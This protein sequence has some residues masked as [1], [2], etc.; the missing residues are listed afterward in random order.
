MLSRE[1]GLAGKSKIA[2]SNLSADLV[3]VMQCGAV[4]GSLVANPLSDRFG[5]K[6]SI[7]V[8]AVFAFIGGL[9]QAFSYGSLVCFYI[10]R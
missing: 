7:L 6:P 5:R 1:Y 8:I 9:L 2:A 4:V 10:G 3:S